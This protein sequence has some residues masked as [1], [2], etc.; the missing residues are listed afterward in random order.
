MTEAQADV[1][2]I[3]DETKPVEEGLKVE[4]AV[5]QAGLVVNELMQD[6]HNL[7]VIRTLSRC[8]K[9]CQYAHQVYYTRRTHSI[10]YL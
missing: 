9:T 3:K 4:E 2:E 5:Q 1:S 6:L 10:P 7:A 8:L